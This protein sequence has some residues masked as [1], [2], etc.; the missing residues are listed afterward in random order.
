MAKSKVKVNEQ[1]L[2]G[3]ISPSATELKPK[4]LYNMQFGRSIMTEKEFESYFREYYPKK[5][6]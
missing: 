5:E 2:K 3:W 1:A 4:E 6:E